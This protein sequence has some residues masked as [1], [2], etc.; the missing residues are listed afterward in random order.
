MKEE[1]IRSLW[2]IRY[3]IRKEFLVLL[4]DPRMRVILF[5]PALLQSLLFGYVASFNLEKVPYAVLDQSRSQSSQ[6]VLAHLDGSG[7][8]KRTADLQNNQ[9]IQQV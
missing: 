6:Q 2:H 5:L 4:A 7:I 9:Q 1:I 3:I 8:F